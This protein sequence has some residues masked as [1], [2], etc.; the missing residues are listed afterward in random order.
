MFV[1]IS[2]NEGVAKTRSC[3]IEQYAHIGNDISDS[4]GRVI[5]ALTTYQGCK[6]G[7]DSQIHSGYDSD[8]AKISANR[9]RTMQA[10]SQKI[11]SVM[12]PKF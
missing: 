5:L 6:F 7:L 4:H 11:L 3:C 10:E 12:L 2:A 9:D 1:E 8:L